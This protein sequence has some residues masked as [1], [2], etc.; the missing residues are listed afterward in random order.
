[1]ND[2]CASVFLG[3]SSK[4]KRSEESITT[5]FLSRLKGK[6]EVEVEVEKNMPLP[7][8]SPKNKKR[9]SKKK[10][11]ATESSWSAMSTGNK[12]SAMKTF[13]HR[14][15]R[16]TLAHNLCCITKQVKIAVQKMETIVDS[17][18]NNMEVLSFGMEHDKSLR[19]TYAHALK[20]LHSDIQLLNDSVVPSI[21]QFVDKDVGII[22]EI[23][24]EIDG[25]I[26]EVTAQCD[27]VI[28]AYPDPPPE[29]ALNLSMFPAYQT[30]RAHGRRKSSTANRIPPPRHVRR[31]S[32]VVT[33]TTNTK[34]RIGSGGSDR[35]RRSIGMRPT[36]DAFCQNLESLIQ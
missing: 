28:Y 34:S 23:E 15:G 31:P 2:V 24:E 32:I 6:G 16:E 21:I 17:L 11:N 9:K 13:V 18:S 12:A 3:S 25:F 14:H 7:P 30:S 29:S 10:K 35:R 26:A 22:E 5:A 19:D 20:N 4:R 33:G 8:S 1:M 27:D 36:M